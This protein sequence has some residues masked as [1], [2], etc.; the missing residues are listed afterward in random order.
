MVL[1]C[2]EKRDKHYPSRSGW[3]S[4]AKA[5]TNFTKPVTKIISGSCIVKLHVMSVPYRRVMKSICGRSP[6]RPRVPQSESV[7]VGQTRW[8]L[9]SAS[10]RRGRS[11]EVLLNPISDEAIAF[12]RSLRYKKLCNFVWAD[13]IVLLPSWTFY[14][15]DSARFRNDFHAKVLIRV[16][17]LSE[18]RIRNGPLRPKES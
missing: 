1:L 17:L 2:P 16:R 13:K 10:S 15:R 4:L 7:C 14:A 3:T 11:K 12:F 6:A 8:S 9:C 18:E 5:V